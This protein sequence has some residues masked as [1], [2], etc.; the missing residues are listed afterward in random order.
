MSNHPESRGFY[1][2]RHGQTE[3]NRDNVSSGGDC[4]V[5]LTDYGRAQAEQARTILKNKGIVPSAIICASLDRTL[6]TAKI[7]NDRLKVDILLNDGLTERHL[8]DWNGQKS[9]ITNRLLRAGKTPPDGESPKTFKTRVVATF[10]DIVTNDIDQILVIGS[11]GTARIL[12]E[13]T[14]YPTPQDFPNGEIAYISV[15]VGEK[16]EVQSAEFVNSN[17]LYER[18]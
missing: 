6:E 12:L 1:F 13:Q 9:V 14:N 11:R 7:I 5:V 16:F 10:T 18:I 15:V 3:A 17:C 8:G 4:N 2:M